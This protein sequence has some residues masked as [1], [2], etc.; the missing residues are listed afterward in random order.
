MG[1]VHERFVRTMPMSHGEIVAVAIAIKH[2]AH[3]IAGTPCDVCIGTV[4]DHG[5]PEAADA[6]ELPMLRGPTGL[7]IAIGNRFGSGASSS[8]EGT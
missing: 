3:A 5:V 6:A 8:G 1:D 2:L 4:A 7:P